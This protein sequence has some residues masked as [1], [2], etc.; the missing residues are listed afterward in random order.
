MCIPLSLNQVPFVDGFKD[1][2][3]DK[4]KNQG[5]RKDKGKGSRTS[6]AGAEKNVRGEHI[7]PLQAPVVSKRQPT[8]QPYCYFSVSNH[9][10]RIYHEERHALAFMRNGRNP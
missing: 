6:E 2:G 7:W 8:K 1:K 9:L 4:G 3:K 10:L 5:K